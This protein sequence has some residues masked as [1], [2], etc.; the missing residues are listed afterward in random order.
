MTPTPTCCQARSRSNPDPDAPSSSPMTPKTPNPNNSTGTGPKSPM[1]AVPSP[2]TGCFM[3]ISG[4]YAIFDYILWLMFY[5][6][7][8]WCYVP[9]A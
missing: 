4:L 3:G 8:I 2:R 5:Y 7:H 9:H 6:V 1:V